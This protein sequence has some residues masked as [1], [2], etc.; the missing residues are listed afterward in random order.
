MYLSC[1]KIVLAQ[2][3]IVKK[4]VT[5]QVFSIS[6]RQDKFNSNIVIFTIIK[7]AMEWSTNA[8]VTFD[9]QKHKK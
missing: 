1:T 9:K 4:I 8:L 2:R 7:S 3:M 6:H 5:A